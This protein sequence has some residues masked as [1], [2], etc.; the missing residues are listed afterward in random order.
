[1]AK[2]RIEGCR[3]LITGASSGIGR[4]L[5][6]ELARQGADLVAI[7]RREEPLNETCRAVCDL[8]RR[9]LPIC[10]DVTNKDSRRRALEAAER[11]FGG[12]DILINNAGISAHGR[13]TEASPDRLRQIMEVNFFAAAELIREATPM[14]SQGR[15][16]IVVNIGSILARRGIPRNSEYCASKFALQGLSEAIRPELATRGIE[17]LM[18]NP[19]PTDTEFF[20]HLLEKDEAP[21]WKQ[22]HGTPTKLVARKTV[23][24]IERGLY[25]IVP[26][27]SGKLL[28]WMNR[29]SPRL[30][31]WVLSRYG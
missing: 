16:P 25:E 28:L 5:A 9:C 31:D 24:A 27:W 18:V 13:F 14:L 15:R 7:A 22:P 10:G 26:S 21:A 17:L 1:M 3:V 20:D 12:L 30:V 4:E 23:R 19:G 6:L 2:R 11:E 29:L 8:G